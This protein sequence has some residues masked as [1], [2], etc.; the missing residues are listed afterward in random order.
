[1]P[2]EQVRSA[3]ANWAPRFSAQ[4]VDP[5]DFARVTGGLERWEDWLDAW[6]A[7]GDAHAALAER[8]AGRAAGRNRV[9]AGW[10]QPLRSPARARPAAS[11]LSSPGV[12]ETSGGRTGP[13]DMPSRPAQALIE[14]MLSI[15]RCL[16]RSHVRATERTGSRVAATSAALATSPCSASV[17]YSRIGCQPGVWYR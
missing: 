13:P 9:A 5:S 6:C 8:L 10:P 7:N 2:D 3:I 4:G 14:A 17:V 12:W 15:C 11:S 1:M 16:P